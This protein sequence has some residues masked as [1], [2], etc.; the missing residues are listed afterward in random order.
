M[1]EN[2]AIEE[3]KE[4]YDFYKSKQEQNLTCTSGI[5]QVIGFKEFCFGWKIT[6]WIPNYLN[7][8]LKE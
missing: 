4:M 6:N 1:M 2:G 8:V 7:M 5:W 3:I